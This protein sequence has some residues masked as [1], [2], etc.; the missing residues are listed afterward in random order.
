[1]CGHRV[2]DSP[3]LGMVVAKRPLRWYA[4]IIFARA[5]RWTRGLTVHDVVD[6]IAV[7]GLLLDQGLCHRVQLVEVAFEDVLR[8]LVVPLDDPTDLLVYHMRRLI[9]DRLLLRH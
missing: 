6:L 3:G 2:T 1:M 9:G 5:L 7:D 4:T 8:T